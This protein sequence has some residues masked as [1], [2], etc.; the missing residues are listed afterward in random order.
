MNEEINFN[1]V[2]DNHEKR[3]FK[4]EVGQIAPEDVDEYV[5]K[6][7]ESFKKS[8][9]LDFKLPEKNEEH[10]TMKFKTLVI[11]K[12]T[13]FQE[14]YGYVTDYGWVTRQSPIYMVSED[15]T[16]G[17]VKSKFPNYNFDG[18]DLVTIEIK[19]VE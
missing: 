3:I 13:D 16:W 4:I 17:E 11:N 19:I 7:Q 9:P 5:K 18:I 8:I 14:F 2:G 15:V 12:G 1:K 6:I 10:L